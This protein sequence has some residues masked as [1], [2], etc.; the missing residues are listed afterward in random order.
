[1]GLSVLGYR[2]WQGR[3]A[4]AWKSPWPISRVSLQMVFRRKLFW[5]LYI[6]ALFNFLVFFSGIYLFYQIDIESLTGARPG[7]VKFWEDLIR[8][9]QEK[10]YLAGTKETYRNFFWLQG[11]VVMAVLALAGSILIG[12]DYQHGSLPFYL[13]KPLG[14]WHY[15]I[16]KFLAVGLFINMT[17]TLPALLLFAECG[18]MEGVRYYQNRW[19]LVLG[20]LGYGAVLTVV[21]SLLVIALAS[22]LRKTVPLMMV[23]VGLLFFGRIFATSL[24]DWLGYGPEWRLIDL[25]NNMYILG[26]WCLEANPMLEENRLFKNRPQPAEWQAALVLLAVCVVCILYLNRRIRAVEVVR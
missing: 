21:L 24:V 18:L 22:W 14:R 9:L 10:L 4:G 3:L 1:M 20:I 5:A 19:E 11:Y 25:W 7:T 6:L 2:P 12:N 26:S 16:G 8:T 23:W 13:S 15:L 17:T